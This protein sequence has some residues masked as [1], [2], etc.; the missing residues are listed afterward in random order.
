[1]KLRYEV[2]VSLLALAVGLPGVV[3]ALLLMWGPSEW[4][5]TNRLLITLIAIAAWVILAMILRRHIV[6][7]LQTVSNLIAALREGDFSVRGRQSRTLQPHDTLEELIREV[8]E[9]ADTLHA[10]RLGALEATALLRKVMEEIDVAVFTFDSEHR[11]KLLNRS[12]ARLLDLPPEKAIGETAESLGLADYLKEGGPRLLDASFPGSTGRW[13]VRRSLFRQEGLPHQLLVLSDI[14]RALRE[15]ELQAWQRIVRVIG[16]EIN[17]SLTPIKSISGSLQSHLRQKTR[18]PDW[19][20]DLARGLTIIGSRSE[21][22]SRFMTAYAR[23]ARLPQPRL[24]SVDVGTLVRRVAGL[25]TR[26][27]V[28]ISSGPA[29]SVSADPD[30]LEQALI[31]LLRNAADAALETGG[32]VAITWVRFPAH[33]ELRIEDEGPGF[34]NTSNLFVP[35]FTTKPQGSGIGLVLS[36]QIAEAHG[37]SLRLDNRVNGHGCVA[38]VRLPL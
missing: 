7:P 24:Q 13:E 11:L 10:Q 30:Q 31:N 3:F 5:A 26:L 9:L 1:M 20:E 19:E 18:P 28:T 6:F 4:V 25:E 2:R 38:Q 33:V 35:F 22:L 29:V 21:S 16:H 14:T 12:G 32:G 17:N 27:P 34:S 8:N 23:L 15:E 36:R 37:G